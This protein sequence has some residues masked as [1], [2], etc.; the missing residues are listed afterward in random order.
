[1][2]E[3]FNYATEASNYIPAK[4]HKFQLSTPIVGLKCV[5]QP[6]TGSLAVNFGDLDQAVKLNASCCTLGHVAEQPVFY[7]GDERSDR[8]L[9]SITDDEQASALKVLR[10]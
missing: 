9:R 1:M 3:A 6:R 8:T 2:D 4:L 10:L 7:A 5:V